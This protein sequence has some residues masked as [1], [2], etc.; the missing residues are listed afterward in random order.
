LPRGRRLTV[1]WEPEIVAR[2]GNVGEQG[3]EHDLPYD[4]PW[5][6]TQR[7]RPLAISRC[8]VSSQLPTAHR[9]IDDPDDYPIRMSHTPC[10]DQ[11]LLVAA[12]R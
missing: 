5:G 10:F 3:T 8:L 4:E 2:L 6:W 1:G 9:L 12:S 7:V 11:F